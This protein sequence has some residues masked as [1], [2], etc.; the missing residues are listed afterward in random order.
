MSLRAHC[1]P[2]KQFYDGH[3]HSMAWKLGTSS[4]AFEIVAVLGCS[5]PVENNARTFL[6]MILPT[7]ETRL[8]GSL[9][10]RISIR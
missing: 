9:S 10:V 2:H 5:F 3:V 1:G 8:T 6:S 4:F 7:P